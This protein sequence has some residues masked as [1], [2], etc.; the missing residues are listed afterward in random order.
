MKVLVTL[1]ILAIVI[2]IL[3]IYLLWF[4]PIP[5]VTSCISGVICICTMLIIN[6]I[7][8]RFKKKLTNKDRRI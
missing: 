8:Q 6:I 5:P 3:G 1:D 4:A 2:A 7:W